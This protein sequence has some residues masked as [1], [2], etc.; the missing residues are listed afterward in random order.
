MICWCK[1][2]GY[3]CEECEAKKK[4]R[5]LSENDRVH[6]KAYNLQISENRPD[7]KLALYI[8]KNDLCVSMIPESEKSAHNKNVI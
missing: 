6:L 3:L 8:L 7:P 4:W 2:I 5:K 1:K